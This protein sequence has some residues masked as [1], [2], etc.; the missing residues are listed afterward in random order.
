MN[1]LSPAEEI[2][3]D[4]EYRAI[5][6]ALLESARGRWFLAEHGRRARR[7]DSALLEDAIGRLQ[8]SLRQ[9]PALLDQLQGE[10]EQLKSHISTLREEMLARPPASPAEALTAAPE[11]VLKATEE[12]HEMAWNLQANPFDPKGCEVIARHAA[13][14]YSLAQGQAEHSERTLAISNS[15]E[16]AVSR[17]E[18]LLDTIQNEREVDP[19]KS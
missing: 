2:D 3:S 8:T 6:K 10:I 19:A 14:I 12:M 16:A 18:A 4:D 9:P 1:R 11:M 17:I 7:L 5:Q 13:N 15:L